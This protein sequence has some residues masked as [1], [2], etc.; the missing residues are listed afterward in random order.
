MG[1]GDLHPLPSSG[2][3]SLKQIAYEKLKWNPG[4]TPNAKISLKSYAQG[5]T[6]TG[7]PPEL[8]DDESI[9]P[10]P[11]IQ[12]IENTRDTDI[13]G[14][15][16]IYCMTGARFSE[17]PDLTGWYRYNHLKDWEIT[18]EWIVYNVHFWT[19]APDMN[20]VPYLATSQMSLL[21]SA[22][23][24]DKIKTATDLPGS[25]Y[26]YL[27]TVTAYID[28]TFIVPVF[29]GNARRPYFTFYFTSN[30]IP[31]G[32]YLYSVGIR[33]VFKALF[34]EMPACW[35]GFWTGNRFC[36]VSYVPHSASTSESLGSDMF[37]QSFYWYQDY[38][39]SDAAAISMI[40]YDMTTL[41][42]YSVVVLNYYDDTYYSS[43]GWYDQ[44]NL[45]SI[46][47]VFEVRPMYGF[48]LVV[49][50]VRTDDLI[51]STSTS[52][53]VGMT[54]RWKGRYGISSSGIC[55]ME[56]TEAGEPTTSNSKVYSGSTREGTFE[57]TLSSLSENTSYKV[58]AF[59]VDNNSTTVYGATKTFSVAMI[60]EVETYDATNIQ[61]DSA[62]VGGNVIS[63]GGRTVSN[64]GIAWNY[65]YLNQWPDI[66]WDNV[67]QCGSGLGEFFTTIDNLSY[68]YVVY[69][70]Y[71]VNTMGVAY[72]ERKYFT[73]AY[74]AGAVP[75]IT[76]NSVTVTGETTAT[77]GG[78]VTD[79][80][81]AVVTRRG[82]CWQDEAYG[83]YPTPDTAFFTEDGTG[84]GSFTS[85]LTNLNPATSY[86]VRAYA[87]NQYGYG[88]GVSRS[89]LTDGTSAPPSV[90]TNPVS[91]IQD[92][93]ATC[94]C[95]IISVGSASTIEIG[96]CWKDSSESGDPTFSDDSKDSQWGSFSAG[97]YAFYLS[98]LDPD[99]N[100]KI[101]AFAR[102]SVGVG[103][104][105]LRYII[106]DEPE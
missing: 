40:A 57:I 23:L 81:D 83:P 67:I 31:S 18:W 34:G 30:P 26:S 27:D 52:M 106:R 95:T 72:G 96:I 37:A 76:T 75:T 24:Y 39:D 53:V 36:D 68:N 50:V 59:A 13:G 19:Y 15:P 32:C 73:P 71:A 14:N 99:T 85:Y 70:A 6:G 46:I 84:T 77:C 61:I 101:R 86:I 43:R 65:N 80:G 48:R 35:V 3:I 1:K 93:T 51:S 22:N 10:P 91:N 41:S 5:I 62:D 102:S 66:N 74:P 7:N 63:S 60:P 105:Q 8:N 64:R 29:Y 25:T 11:I 55:Y 104:G 28:K 17:S 20:P 42:D 92:N 12:S 58:R 54:V 82:V 87:E 21:S 33:V 45:Q 98:S 88:Y 97:S 2:P 100:Y 44:F 79:Q 56:S 89:F 4:E 9:N 47:Q 78:N 38:S 103:Y 94:G 69:R 90:S 49:P 16:V